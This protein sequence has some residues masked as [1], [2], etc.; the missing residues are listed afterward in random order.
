M[1]LRLTTEVRQVVIAAVLVA[2]AGIVA[3]LVFWTESSRQEE[4]SQEQQA[5]EIDAEVLEAKTVGEQVELELFFCDADS[6]S[7]ERLQTLQRTL[8][9]TDD[10]L[11]LARQIL[12]QVL[13]G[14]GEGKP[15]V[16]PPQSRTRQVYLLDDGTAVVD[17][18]RETADGLAGSALEEYCAL[19]SISRSL[20]HN[21]PSIK[22]VKFLVEGKDRAT[23][24]GHVSLREPFL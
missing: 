23:F 6:Q 17:L 4:I 16:F 19:R 10:P 14:P 1:N 22:R 8:F 9:R 15:N 12:S 21:V 11:I 13:A 2:V 20:T 18:S 24:A 7:S 5:A 3:F